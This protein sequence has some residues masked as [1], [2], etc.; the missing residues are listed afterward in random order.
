MIPIISELL[1]RK[2]TSVEYNFVNISKECLCILIGF[3]R[4]GIIN[5]QHLLILCSFPNTSYVT[6]LFSQC[7]DNIQL[8]SDIG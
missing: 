2:Y 6:F 8:S 5:S 3:L 4:D 1:Q 7:C